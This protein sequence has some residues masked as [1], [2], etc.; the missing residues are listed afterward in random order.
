[1]H[2]YTHTI[3]PRLLAHVVDCTYNS[4]R[5]CGFDERQCTVIR[6]FRNINKAFFQFA[7]L[8]ETVQLVQEA[9]PLGSFLIAVSQNQDG[10]LFI[11]G[12]RE[13][14]CCHLQERKRRTTTVKCI[15]FIYLFELQ[16]KIYVINMKLLKKSEKTL[17]LKIQGMSFLFAWMTSDA[18][19]ELTEKSSSLKPKESD[20][21]VMQTQKS[22]SNTSSDVW[23][24]V[25]TNLMSMTW[26]T[27]TPGWASFAFWEII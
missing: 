15:T 9:D 7:L 10:A 3:N 6:F 13:Q 12:W 18:K 20:L 21:A 5:L 17:T 25:L 1:M 2:T 8:Q 4:S 22:E 24:E 26:F 11:A 14:W 19:T 23:F 16:Y 27:T